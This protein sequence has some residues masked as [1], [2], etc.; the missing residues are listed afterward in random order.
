M[1]RWFVVTL[2]LVV[3]LSF[4]AS[5]AV[6]PSEASKALSKKCV[7]QML[8]IPGQVESKDLEQVCEKVQ[9]LAECQSHQGLPLFHYEVPPS[10]PQAKRILVLSMMHG[11]EVQAG[12]V[13]RRW[14][15]RLLSLPAR[16]HWR[17]IPILNP[18]GW[19]LNQRMNSKG[20]DL[21]RNFPSKD[22][23]QS[24]HQFWEKSAQ[25]NPRRYPGPAAGSE[26]ETRC[27]MRHIEDFDPHFIVAIHSPYGVLDFDGPTQLPLPAIQ[28][29][30]WTRLGTFPG[31]LGR[32]MWVDQSIPVLTVELKETLS[33][34]DLEYIDR[35]HDTLGTVAILSTQKK[36]SPL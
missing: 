20:V 22:W 25:K 32:F 30:K 34:E 3:F 36:K 24:A 15:M 14:M 8:K 35:L 29:L 23:P 31:S 7:E 17:V 18:D 21:N 9:V 27:A 4:T 11:D 2:G 12:I 28:G 19:A 10:H 13:A 16:N 26:P 1:I 33:V 5:G 6:E